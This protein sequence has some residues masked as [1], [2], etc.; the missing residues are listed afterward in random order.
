MNYEF[1][2]NTFMTLDGEAGI[3]TVDEKYN[4]VLSIN[5]EV[6]VIRDVQFQN[7][8]TGRNHFLAE[9]YDRALDCSLT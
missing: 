1:L 8:Q 9:L 2:A 4:V 6:L 5:G 3:W 7:P